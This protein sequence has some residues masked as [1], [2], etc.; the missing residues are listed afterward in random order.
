MNTD[1]MYIVILFTGTTF[2]AG[3]FTRARKKGTRETTAKLGSKCNGSA[4]R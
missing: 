2:T 4:G 3:G 1:K